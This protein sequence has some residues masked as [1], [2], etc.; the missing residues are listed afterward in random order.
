LISQPKLTKLLQEKAQ[1]YRTSIDF[2]NAIHKAGLSQP[3]CMIVELLFLNKTYDRIKFVLLFTD[4]A[5]E[6]YVDELYEFLLQ[7]DS[8]KNTELLRFKKKE[9]WWTRLLNLFYKKRT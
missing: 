5:F 1:D 7:Y 4:K 9:S 3:C 2:V 6:K 8:N